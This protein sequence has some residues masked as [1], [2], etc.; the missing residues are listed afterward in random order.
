VKKL[1]KQGI[2]IIGLA[3]LMSGCASEDFASFMNTLPDINHAMAPAAAQSAANRGDYKQA[4]EIMR[5]DAMQQMMRG[6]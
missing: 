5:N 4:N 1:I 6:Q 3:I 2:A